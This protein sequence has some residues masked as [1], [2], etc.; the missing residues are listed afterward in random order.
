MS[1][2]VK[3][4]TALF[5]ATVVLLALSF[6]F[7]SCKVCKDKSAGRDGTN[8]SGDSDNAGDSGSNGSS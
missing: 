7:S 6:T 1:V 5:V 2:S 3:S 8:S 4:K